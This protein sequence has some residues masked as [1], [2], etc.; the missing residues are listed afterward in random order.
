MTTR[1]LDAL[2][3][4]RA[5]A[6]I[7]ASNRPGSVGNV[8]ARNLLGAGFS[9]PVMPV[10]PHATEICST[11]SY[12]TVG[13]LPT[14][15]DL[16][17]I[18][19]PPRVIPGIIA[20]LGQLGCRAAVVITAGFDT[21][22]RTAM[23]TAGRPY[24]MRIVGPN[25]LGF[26]SPVRG[27]NASF[28]H[29]SPP[30]GALAFVTQSGAIAT[31]IIDWAAGKNIGFS[32][33]ISLG[34]MSDVDFG[35]LLD[36][37]ALD[38][39]TRA[40]LL[41]AETVTQARKFMSAGRIA[42]RAKPVIVIKGGRS[43]SGAAAAASH[44]GALAGADA[45]Y[46][47][48]FRRAGMLRVDTLRELFDAAQTLASGL[49][50]QGDRLTILTNGGGLGVL[51][52][53]ALESAGGRLAD[54]KPE[55][56]AR[57]DKVLPAAW[58]R[59]NPIDIIGDAPG[60]RYTAALDALEDDGGSDGLLVMNC[61]TGV[62]DSMDAAEATVRARQQHVR[63]PMLACWMGESSTAGPRDL[64]LR[65]GIPSYET[66]DEAV[67]AFLHLAEYTRNQKALFETPTTVPTRTAPNSREQAKAIINAVLA[68]KRSILTEPEAK[69]VLLAYNIPV[70]ATRSVTSP[71][72]AGKAAKEIGGKVALK[73]LSRQ[74][75]HK[76][77]VGGVQLGL[78]GAENTTRAAEE[79]L[80]RVA[81]AR[82]DAVI[83]GF[84]VQ[85]M[86]RRP[87]AQEL[88]LGAVVDRTFGPCL[89]FG[90]GGIAAEVVADRS[91][92]LPPLNSN[93]ARAMIGRTRVAKLL[94]GY[95]DRPA[96][97]LDAVAAAL[98]S[99][100][101]LVIDFP[102]I[103]E[104]DINP[105]LADNESV[106]ALDA[107]IIVRKATD[108][109][110][111][112]IRP[113]PSELERTL[114]VDGMQLEVRPIRPEDSDRLADM[115]RRTSSDDLRR[116]LHGTINVASPPVAAR[117]SQIDYDRE[118][119]LLALLP[120]SSAAGAV[121]LVFDPTFETAEGAVIVRTDMQN[122]KIGRSL[123]QAALDYA[124]GRGARMVWGDILADNTE[125][126]GMALKLGAR[127]SPSPAHP[128]LVRA[129]FPTPTDKLQPT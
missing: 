65:S 81:T 25:C 47:A 96:A 10:N 83:D 100:S 108:V 129:D 33:L 46:D 45:V 66:P 28:A 4:P 93:L 32:H 76:T 105:L 13:D 54:L 21:D 97:N 17:V 3:A 121:R 72:D 103:A 101:D 11:R 19:T 62:A 15:P 49:H 92:G 48:V 59:S 118:M 9:G 27:I 102:E 69:E 90:H 107:R 40:I 122:R 30:A 64:F 42:A 75:T 6:L 78:E 8:L 20:D 98:V 24:L 104:L 36:F 26:L 60:E 14:V 71:V 110:G 125:A 123:L 31:S 34:E 87:K 23:L 67:F 1:N 95:R 73:I 80:A 116:R 7:G 77:D 82:A 85:Q 51:A 18:A 68:D 29:M 94:E 115:A 44:T 35:D 41:Y 16:A 56:I 37:L 63:R 126:I 88:L 113:Y 79:M 111:L 50:V 39:D 61:P 120:D 109:P 117:L 5:I 106:I 58:S 127:I 57:L 84:T 43:K 124:H 74:I 99:L 112:A 55:T 12:P 128:T 22:L 114:A 119:V 91:M 2:F 70:V 38:A 52:A 53:D 89:M 86:V